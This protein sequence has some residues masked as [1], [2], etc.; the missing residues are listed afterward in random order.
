MT[1]RIV[2]LLASLA[3]CLAVTACGESEAVSP[4]TPAEAPSLEPIT[5]QLES[6]PSAFFEVIPTAERECVV[7]AWGQTRFDGI[8][9]GAVPTAQESEAASECL[10][11]TTTARMMLGRLLAGAGELSDATLRCASQR[12]A[13]ADLAG[14]RRPAG[15]GVASLIQATFCLNAEERTALEASG[16]FALGASIDAFECLAN[17]VGDER[18]Q[19]VM[20][21]WVRIATGIGY[22]TNPPRAATLGV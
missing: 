18:F 21:D 4:A 13:A 2:P 22:L 17:E 7:A 14:I 20:A 6:E 15:G 10:S 1:R 12:L 16:G 11:D 8:V 5:A 9:G 3:V 19:T